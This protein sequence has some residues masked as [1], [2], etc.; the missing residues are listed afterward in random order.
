MIILYELYTIRSLY[1]YKPSMWTNM[2]WFL[3]YGCSKCIGKA[4]STYTYIYIYIQYTSCTFVCRLLCRFRFKRSLRSMLCAVFIIFPCIVFLLFLLFSFLFL[5]LFEIE[6][7][8]HRDAFLAHNAHM[9]RVID[10]H[11]HCHTI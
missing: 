3:R 5:L 4:V 2:H 1:T 9:S 6:P 8:S 10:R 7:H 11:L